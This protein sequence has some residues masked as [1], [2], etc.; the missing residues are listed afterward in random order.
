MAAAS[1]HHVRTAALAEAIATELARAAHRFGEQGQAATAEA[2]LRQ[3]RQHR[4]Q[5]LR[6]RAEAVAERY[7]R[8][9]GAAGSD[10]PV[11]S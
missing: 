11:L 5:A 9:I 6:L 8:T 3:A 1:T 4:I 7:L 10:G 2:L